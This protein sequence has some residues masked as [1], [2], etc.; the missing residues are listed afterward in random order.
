MRFLQLSFCLILGGAALAAEPPAELPVNQWVKL[1]TGGIWQRRDPALVYLPK[2]KRF[3]LALGS[4]SNTSKQQHYDEM[5][6]SLADRKWKNR[7]PP[8]KDWGPEVGA[9]KA[10]RFRGVYYT[11][12]DVEGNVR[13][14]L[15]DSDWKTY[16][17]YTLD[18]DRGKLVAFIWNHTLEYDIKARKWEEIKV[19]GNPAGGPWKHRAGIFK[20]WF[21]S[22]C[23][24]PVNK[25]VLL[26]GG[27]NGPSEFNDP[28]T[29]IYSPAKKEWRRH[30][31]GS[32]EIKKLCARAKALRKEAQK[33][34]G[35][36]SNRFF[37]TETAEV[38]KV[39]LSVPSKTLRNE[40]EALR[41]EVAGAA[42]KGHEKEKCG[43]AAAEL[44]EVSKL[45]A[46]LGDAAEK[47]S[48]KTALSARRTLRKAED[49]LMS[50]PPPRASSPMVFDPVSKKIVL[51]G[52]DRLDMFY[53]D[54][55]VY[56]CATRQWEERRPR[57]SPS[58]R[59]GHAFL[60][61]P[62]SKKLVLL[63]G[64]TTDPKYTGATGPLYRQ[65]DFQA[66]TYNV[67]ENS[68][69]LVKDWEEPAPRTKPA[70]KGAPPRHCYYK[71]NP[72]VAA[73]SDDDV[74]AVIST[75]G[76]R[77]WCTLACRLDA[78]KTDAAGT[79]RLGVAPGA[80]DWRDGSSNPNWFVDGPQ[81][82]EAAF[83]ARLKALPANAW[84]LLKPPRHPLQCRVWGTAVL[85][86]HRQ[87]IYRWSGGHCSYVWN[88]TDIPHFSLRTGRSSIKY[89]PSIPAHSIGICSD[90]PSKSDFRGGAWIPGHSYHSYGYD[91]VAR[92][93]V[94][95]GHGGHSFEYDP[96]DGT[97]N[98]KRL[99]KGLGNFYTDTIC[100]TPNG[101]FLWNGQGDL[102]RY[103]AASK[104][105]MKLKLSGAKLP[106]T[107]TDRSGMSYDSKRN[108]LL[109][110]SGQ[111]RK[112]YDGQ[113]YAV[114]MKT[115]NVK[116]L[117]PAGQKGVSKRLKAGS[118]R[119]TC[120]DAAN[121]LFI[122]GTELLDPPEGKFRR[123]AAYDCAGNRWVSLKLG[124]KIHPV[125]PRGRG[126]ARN[127][128]LG[129]MYD[130]RRSL[131]W[132]TDTLNKIY[133]LRIDVKTADVE[134]L[135]EK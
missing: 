60:L 30:E 46:G 100:S 133:V 97:W 91:P 118:C 12:K 78:S 102:Y 106:K 20:L 115:L 69:D 125:D 19:T 5:H 15:F 99:P 110:T 92:K 108:R 107:C 85:D 2:E 79:A 47:A 63:G 27:N 16:Y 72:C 114:D 62:K 40:V 67:K 83:Q 96:D 45:L 71:G 48:L 24:D 68:W 52:G 17:Q 10:P 42:L 122:I 74:V 84:V 18:T 80:R 1:E 123:T 120:Y 25:E 112:P 93:M 81:P 116:A 58:P 35:A 89:A 134:P 21:G 26:F 28:R 98:S 131:L 50:E 55:W 56:D 77:K 75:D 57:V 61:L 70:P 88:G 105:W 34:Y 104:T 111:Y 37:L 126:M 130:A 36:Y 41:K 86:P 94:L 87:A 9:S 11:M 59:A 6:F 128:S 82:D 119:D 64:Y 29:W 53:A 54:T 38:G 124:G 23:Y 135:G 109:C 49:S 90:Q 33:L 73:A 95:T 32:A 121:D 76:Y 31:T 4:I 3:L 66:W 129:L 14:S 7:F 113:V 22:I 103:D 13:P 44:A 101:A 65:L 117:N 8:G 39:K 51:F 127:V 132:A 43:W